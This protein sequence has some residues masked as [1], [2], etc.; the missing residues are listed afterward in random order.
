MS[1]D[2]DC[3]LTPREV[4]A[5]DDRDGFSAAESEGFQLQAPVSEFPAEDEYVDQVR[6]FCFRI[7]YLHFIHEP[8]SYNPCSSFSLLCCGSFYTRVDLVERGCGRSLSKATQ[9]LLHY[10]TAPPSQHSRCCMRVDGG[11]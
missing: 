3:I 4:T 11:G 10:S 2:D 5:G 7:Y 1:L 8:A 6:L 9:Q